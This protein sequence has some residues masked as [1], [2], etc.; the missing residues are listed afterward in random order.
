MAGIYI[1]IP[2]CRKRCL[3]CDFF[4]STDLSDKDRYVEECCRELQSRREYLGDENIRT[5]YFGGGT[6]SLLTSD[7]FCKIFDTIEK[8]FPF[9]REETT[10]I[11][12]EANPDDLTDNYLHSLRKLPFNR[13]SIGI[14]S[15]RNEDLLFLNRRHSATAA[16][17][18]VRECQKAGYYNISID[19]IY[20]LPGQTPERWKEN[21]R[22]A[23]ALDVPHISAYHL[24]Y[25][26]GT[27]L[28]NQLKKGKIKE[29][30][31]EVSLELFEIT[32]DAL[33]AAGYEHYEI[34][35]FAKRGFRSQHNSGYWNGSHYL[36]IGAAAHS[37]NGISRSLNG[38][39]TSGFS[40]ESVEVIDKKTAYND[41]IIT[42]LR[43]CEGISLPELERLHG[44]EKKKYCLR[45]AKTFLEGGKLLRIDD[46]L[47]LSREGIFISDRIMSELME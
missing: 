16:I 4:S 41:Y 21:L 10:E 36:G 19:L 9:S 42:R 30:E 6:P 46:R 47:T 5:I 28:H 40:V 35:N 22:Q 45:H 27:T 44:E 23:I 26:E 37:F 8:Y 15:F 2:F 17:R 32:M 29:V 7:D 13:L 24:I 1:H 20:G 38:N 31:E 34:S 12:L 43:T 3:Y 18:A 33:A 25:E 14:Q 11:T 39:R